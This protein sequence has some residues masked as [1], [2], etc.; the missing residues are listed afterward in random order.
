MKYVDPDEEIIISEDGFEERNFCELGNI[1]ESSAETTDYL[2]IHDTT[3]ICKTFLNHS[4]S[5]MNF[6][7]VD[8]IR[9]CMGDTTDEEIIEGLRKNLLAA[10]RDGKTMVINIAKS[11]PDFD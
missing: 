9:R 7:G 2:F 6:I 1:L 10:V 4:V 8:I 11:S 5:I 3:D